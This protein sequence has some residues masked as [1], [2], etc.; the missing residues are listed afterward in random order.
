MRYSFHQTGEF[1]DTQ[2]LD[3]FTADFRSKGW[4]PTAHVVAGTDIGLTWRVVANIEARYS[5][6]HATLNQDFSS[7]QPIDLNGLRMSAGV[8]FRF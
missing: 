5:W 7:F 6:A 1:V 4:A 3:I 8:F 2:T